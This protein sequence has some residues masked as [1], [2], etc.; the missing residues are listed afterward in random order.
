MISKMISEFLD[1]LNEWLVVP[2]TE[3]ENIGRRL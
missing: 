3:R 1:Y 2:L